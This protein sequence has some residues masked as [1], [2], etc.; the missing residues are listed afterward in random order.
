MIGFTDPSILL[1]EP[2]LAAGPEAAVKAREDAL[3]QAKRMA[4]AF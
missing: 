4:K 3:A 1:V 2:T